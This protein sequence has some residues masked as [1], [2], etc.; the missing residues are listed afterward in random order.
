MVQPSASSGRSFMRA[1]SLST[2]AAIC[3]MPVASAPLGAASRPIAA[4]GA[5]LALPRNCIGEPVAR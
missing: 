1:A 3:A 4:T 2:I 5:A